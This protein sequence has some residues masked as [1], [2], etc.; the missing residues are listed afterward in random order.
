MFGKV[1]CP[2]QNE[3]SSFHPRSPYG[4]AKVFGHH[5]TVNYRESYGLFACSGICFNHESPRRGCEFVT[6]K[7]TMQV[8][9]IKSGLADKLQMG[10]L[11]VR[12]D[13]GFAGDYVPAMW[14]M[15]QQ[16][17]PDDYVMATG[18]THTVRE[19][20]EIAFGYVG[21][22]WQEYVEIDPKFF[23]PAEVD[24]L[25]GD[26]RKA[27]EVLRWEP[28]VTFQELIQ[29]MVQADLS[30]LAPSAIT[31]AVQSVA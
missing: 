18:E 8:A 28:T 23:R 21:L 31:S 3:K 1:S 10:N 15:L 6:R 13:W 25:C 7:V 27:R 12:R 29:M 17:E 24:Y 5:I 9:R 16:A 20:L 30:R 14:M 4:V 11:D 26:S 2:L 22:D 19:L